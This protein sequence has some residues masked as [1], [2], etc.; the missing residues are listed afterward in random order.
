MYKNIYVPVNNSAVSTYLINE[1]IRLAKFNLARI[2]FIH[3]IN[4]NEEL[5]KPYSLEVRHFGA[6]KYDVETLQFI[7]QIKIKCCDNKIGAEIE[8]IKSYC[9]IDKAIIKDAILWGADLIMLGYCH[10][11]GSIFHAWGDNV[12]EKLATESNLPLLLIHKA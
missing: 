11:L 1:A 7:D 10:K 6:D 12:I 4:L 5:F 8:V 2:R 9:D 3:I